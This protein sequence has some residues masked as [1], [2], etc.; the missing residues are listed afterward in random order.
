MKNPHFQRIYNEFVDASRQNREQ[1]DEIKLLR[2]ELQAARAETTSLKS[3]PRFLMPPRLSD[4]QADSISPNDSASQVQYLG[5]GSQTVVA[6][7]SSHGA[8]PPP[9]PP[10]SLQ[11]GLQP[12]IRPAAYPES[13]LWTIED[14]NLSRPK[15]DKCIRD[16]KGVPVTLAQWRAIRMTTR[17]IISQVFPLSSFEGDNRKKSYLKT[18]HGDDWI[19][20]IFTLERKEPLVALCAGHWKADQVLGV[21]LKAQQKKKTSPSEDE[22][23]LDDSDE[24]SS[25]DTAPTK[26]RRL[27]QPEPAPKKNA[28]MFRLKSSRARTLLTPPNS[29]LSPSPAP[30]NTSPA[31]SLGA[32]APCTPS[33]GAPSTSPASSPGT[34]GAPP[35]PSLL[36]PSASS[37]SSLGADASLTAPSLGTPNTSPAIPGSGD[38]ATPFPADEAMPADDDAAPSPTDG[39]APAPIDGAAPAPTNGADGATPALTS[40]AT[41]APTGEATPTPADGASFESTTSAAAGAKPSAA[42]QDSI[43]SFGFQVDHH[44]PIDTSFIQTNETCS[45]L[46]NALSREFPVLPH[47]LSLLNVMAASPNFEQ[48]QPSSEVL[49]FIA[50][51]NDADPNTFDEESEDETNANWGHYQFTAGGINCRIGNTETACR[52]IAAALKTCRIARHI[53]IKRGIQSTNFLSDAYLQNTIEILW[54]LWVGAG[55]PQ[56]APK[57]TTRQS[58]RKKPKATPALSDAAQST[59]QSTSQSPQ[60]TE[61][62][63]DQLPADGP[64]NDGIEADEL[65]DDNQDIRALLMRLQKDELK[66]W[67]ESHDPTAPTI[68]KLKTKDD[69]I[70]AILSSTNI[71]SPDDVENISQTVSQT[72]AWLEALETLVLGIALVK[73]QS[74]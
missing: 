54:E 16:Q 42:N 45:G 63:N 74:L 60:S 26:K 73:Q 40:G 34:P 19:S 68:S 20:A 10:P 61:N 67:I 46:I 30:A 57:A 72:E 62:A 23:D 51:I 66:T 48:G 49:E 44:K 55:G 7:I 41:P 13:I 53:C 64:N 8:P 38:G 3:D 15:M 52:L 37:T 50:R 2:T 28:T 56:G 4:M 29:T 1:V 59:A 12:A 9:P 39:A 6:P 24:D 31:S 43:G 69:L 18:Y 27:V 47:A 32:P 17:L 33:L 70:T 58:A 25:K 22:A 36:P 5:G 14:W 65:E 71:P 35:P 21:V 11:P